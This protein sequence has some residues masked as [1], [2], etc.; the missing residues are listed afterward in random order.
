M[1]SAQV[2]SLV[3]AI[4]VTLDQVGSGREGVQAIAT[5][6]TIESVCPDVGPEQSDLLD[7]YLAHADPIDA[8]IRQQHALTGQSLVVIHVDSDER[9]KS[10][11]AGG[12]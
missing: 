12:R 5:R 4:R 2:I 3:K 11:Q 10:K 6:E 9:V 8:L 7:A 1:T